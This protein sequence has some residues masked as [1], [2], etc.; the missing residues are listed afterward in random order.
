MLPPPGS[1]APDTGRAAAPRWVRSWA[2]PLLMGVLLLGGWL[3]LLALAGPARAD[4]APAV[5]VA[6]AHG[7]Q[8]TTSASSRAVPGRSKDHRRPA[9]HPDAAVHGTTAGGPAGQPSVHADLAGGDTT[10]TPGASGAVPD[11]DDTGATPGTASDAV[12]DMDDVPETQAAATVLSTPPPAVVTGRPVDARAVV[13]APPALTTLTTPTT[14]TAPTVPTTPTT[15]PTARVPAAPSLVAAPATP[16]PSATGGS[17]AAPTVATTPSPAPATVLGATTTTS[18]PVT[19]A[20]LPATASTSTA[21]TTATSGS[22]QR[23][24]CLPSPPPTCAAISTGPSSG[25]SGTVLASG[26]AT[27]RPSLGGTASPPCPPCPAATSAGAGGGAAKAGSADQLCARPSPSGTGSTSFPGPIAPAASVPSAVL[28]ASAPVRLGTVAPPVVP[29]VAQPVSSV[30][31]VRVAPPCWVEGAAKAT[32]SGA[33]SVPVTGTA[34]SQRGT[35]SSQG[36]DTGSS[37]ADPRS[38]A[39]PLQPLGPGPIPLPQ[40]PIPEAPPSPP[41]GVSGAG[42]NA[43]WVGKNGAPGLPMVTLSGS[44]AEV[45]PVGSVLHPVLDGEAPTGTS[46]EPGSTPD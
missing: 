31:T 11:A 9:G 26:L 3:V 19:I 46:G 30:T 34:R 4:D 13:P 33:G 44:A 1:L 15:V 41:T 14:L 6:S 45:E 42:G 27:V 16:V 37:A 36:A 8:D 38:G 28:A 25:A 24:A 35:S 18:C 40:Q 29:P 17:G 32:H 2:R 21:T 39:P 10:A 23:V 43:G 5:A 20:I 22:T 7:G 12:P